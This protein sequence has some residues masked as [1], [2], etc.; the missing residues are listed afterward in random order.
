LNQLLLDIEPL[1]SRA[2]APSTLVDY[3]DQLLTGKRLPASIKNELATYLLGVN[4]GTGA[5][6]GIQRAL[7]A[8]YLIISSPYYLIQT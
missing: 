2:G 6:A 3:L 1:R 8:L 4:M 5:S 7:D